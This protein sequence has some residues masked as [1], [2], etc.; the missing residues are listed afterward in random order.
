VTTL[1]HWWQAASLLIESIAWQGVP[2]IAAV[3]TLGGLWAWRKQRQNHSSGKPRP[4]AATLDWTQLKQSLA[5]DENDRLLSALEN[6]I[7]R[8]VL[9]KSDLHASLNA[10]LSS[11][12][13]DATH[14]F[15]AIFLLE[16]GDYVLRAGRGISASSGQRL[17]LDSAFA[18]RLTAERIIPLEQSDRES[19][20]F[21]FLTS[22]KRRRISG[23]TVASIGDGMHH[24]GIFVTS[25][26]QP[27]PASLN[28]RVNLLRGLMGG[29][30]GHLR[31][32]RTL[33]SQE[34][35]IRTSSDRLELRAIL[36]GTNDSPTRNVDEF[37]N[38]LR[39][40]VG[41]ARAALVTPCDQARRST[42]WQHHDMRSDDGSPHLFESEQRLIGLVLSGAKEETVGPAA[43]T[44]AGLGPAIGSAIVL[45]VSCSQHAPT[46][47]C[48]TRPAQE[49]F[50]AD[51]VELARWAAA[52]LSEAIEQE[53]SRLEIERQARQDGLT[54]LSN[55]RV[56]DEQIER[57][58]QFA[59]RSGD[60]VSLILLDLDRFKSINDTY[61]H[62]AGDEVLRRTAY[63][64]REAVERTRSTDRIVMARLGGEELAV[65]AP[66]VT[67]HGAR[68]IAEAIRTAVEENPVEFEGKTIRVTLSGGLATFPD[69]GAMASELITAADRMLYLAKEQGRNRI[70]GF[71]SR[72]VEAL[73]TA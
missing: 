38:V 28:Q 30:A 14:D 59:R 21:H 10:F 55:R 3:V 41:A 35:Q 40:A 5:G 53:R 49:D 61:G 71:D 4:A 22:N 13:V 32:S 8:E 7:L 56:F 11:Y 12:L 18:R 20:A 9:S 47:L 43:C 23:V 52:L 50:P 31:R 51:R 33:E 19:E 54:G 6:R 58:L 25:S 27:A 57:E 48:L 29:I 34:A 64:L 67:L 1:L 45:P 66:G 37:L 2:I 60:S 62:P 69:Q 26:L 24:V 44:V 46:F 15:A 39:T 70:I 65:L 16:D 73:A 72:P 17:M 36:D 42:D 68:R 63:Q